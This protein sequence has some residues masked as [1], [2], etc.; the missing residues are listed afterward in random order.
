MSDTVLAKNV[1][2]AFFAP[3]GSFIR[4]SADKLMP[5]YLKWFGTPGA[6]GCE[7]RK[8]LVGTWQDV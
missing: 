3:K 1:F 2:E 8:T 6:C 4:M 7:A 5:W